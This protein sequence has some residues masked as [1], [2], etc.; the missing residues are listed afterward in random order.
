MG[1]NIYQLCDG[2][3]TVGEVTALVI[4]NFKDITRERIETDVK[5][6]LEA[7]VE[8]NFLKREEAPDD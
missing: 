5:H 7:L 2:S 1:V 8:I 6:F 3:M 4:D